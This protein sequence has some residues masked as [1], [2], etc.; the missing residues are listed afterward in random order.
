MSLRLRSVFGLMILLIAF[1]GCGGSNEETVIKVAPP[2]PA[3]EL[4]KTALTDL[5][6]TGTPVG[7]GGM[8][9]QQ[10]VDQIGKADPDKAATLSKGVDSLM[11]MTDPAKVKAKASEMLKQL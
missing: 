1:A 7:S 11:S 4:L 6:K 5:A 8:T 3:E 10:H 9:L 2:P